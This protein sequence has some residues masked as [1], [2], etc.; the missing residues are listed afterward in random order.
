MKD[1]ELVRKYWTSMGGRQFDK[2]GDCM[3][4]D[5]V[6]YFPNT[7]EVFTGREAFVAFNKQYPGKWSIQ[8]EKLTVADDTVVTAVRAASEDGSKSF[9]AASFFTI[10]DGLIREI[11]E[12][13]GENGEPPA[14][15]EDCPYVERY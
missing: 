12:Y 13:W 9:Y 5:A 1:T 8:I 14:W 4:Q 6:V 15:R 10:K 3:A 11:T 7:R 2:A